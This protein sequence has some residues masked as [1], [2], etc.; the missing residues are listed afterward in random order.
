M[1]APVAESHFECWCG[2]VE[3]DGRIRRH[4]PACGYHTP[5]PANF[6]VECGQPIVLSRTREVVKRRHN[7]KVRT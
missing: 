3:E 2:A 1:E 6:C 5:M 4:C 7:R